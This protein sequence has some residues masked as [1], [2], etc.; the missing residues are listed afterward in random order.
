MMMNDGVHDEGSSNVTI[1]IAR[2]QP[3]ERAPPLTVNCIRVTYRIGKQTVLDGV[4]AKFRPGDFTAVMGGWRPAREG[5]SSHW[6]YGPHPVLASN[7]PPAFLY[8]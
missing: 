7:H 8:P 3:A 6:S 1:K 4:S 5:R 2:G